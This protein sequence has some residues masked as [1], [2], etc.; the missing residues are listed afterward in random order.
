MLSDSD[1]RIRNEAASALLEF[2]ISQLMRI[3]GGIRI[4]PKIHLMS[5]FIAE[6]LSNEIPF[7]MDNPSEP[8]AGFQLDLYGIKEN[9]RQIKQ[10]LGI[11]LF[12]LTN[13]LFDLKSSENLVRH[14]YITNSIF[15]F[16]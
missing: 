11:Y 3:N 15:F 14:F 13:M 7:S 12:D 9:N 10:V 16:H 6:I 2:N 8:L 1:A 5:E 4:C